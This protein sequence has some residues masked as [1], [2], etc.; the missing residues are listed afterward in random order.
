[1]QN[2]MNTIR[3]YYEELEHEFRYV[4]YS[5]TFS[6]DKVREITS[7]IIDA[8]NEFN[9]GKLSSKIEKFMDENIVNYKN[10]FDTSKRLHEQQNL[11][12][13]NVTKILLSPYFEELDTEYQNMEN[14]GI[15]SDDKIEDITDK[16]IDFCAGN[17]TSV[18]HINKIEK[19]MEDIKVGFKKSFDFDVSK[20]EQMKKLEEILTSL[21]EEEKS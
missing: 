6:D 5:K 9:N 15:Y 8:Y 12:G 10:L 16:I 19:I 17:V 1:M 4:S 2:F 11:I 14:S 7:K 21:N 20:R 13:F 18:I 3:K